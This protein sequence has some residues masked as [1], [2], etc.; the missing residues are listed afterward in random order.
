ML[1]KVARPQVPR[2][3][4]NVLN[5]LPLCPYNS[6]VH[7]PSIPSHT[8]G[9]LLEFPEPLELQENYLRKENPPFCR[10]FT[11]T[12][13]NRTISCLVE[14]RDEN[15]GG[16][17]WVRSV[18]ALYCRRSSFSGSSLSFLLSR[19][20][21]SPSHASHLPISLPPLDPAVHPTRRG[22]GAGS[23]ATPIRE[24][25][26][27]FSTH[28]GVHFPREAAH[29]RE[30]VLFP[31][32]LAAL[33]PLVCLPVACCLQ[34]FAPANPLTSRRRCRW[35]TSAVRPVC[36]VY[37]QSASDNFSKVFS[38]RHRCRCWQRSQTSRGHS[39]QP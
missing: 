37:F 35:S 19:P 20:A 38:S 31:S 23:A 34:V 27:L 28:N 8:E 4:L 2:P 29:V 1:S 16:G 14:S 33:A 3:C 11:H 30:E 12:K 13:K 36:P 9:C 18:S 26:P 5:L 21:S 25:S 39:V 32:D 7:G 17:V 24:E 10:Y 15:C 6:F 22:N